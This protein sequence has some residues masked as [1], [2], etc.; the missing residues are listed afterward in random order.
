MA[1]SF[2]P[3]P[4]KGSIMRSVRRA[5]ERRG[6]AGGWRESMTLRLLEKAGALPGIGPACLGWAGFIH[7][8]EGRYTQAVAHYEAARAR[9]RSGCAALRYDTGI[10]LLKSGDAARAEPELRAAVACSG[11][12]PWAMLQLGLCL[13]SLNLPQEAERCFRSCLD[14]Q[15]DCEGGHLGLID[16]LMR[17]QLASE[18]DAVLAAA[19]RLPPH[20]LAGFKLPEHLA[21]F[22]PVSGQQ[23]EAIRELLDRRPPHPLAESAALFLGRIET[24]RSN[25][26]TAAALFRQAGLHR[27]GHETAAGNLPATM[28]AVL[29][30]GQAKAGTSSLFHHLSAHPQFEPSLLKEP[31][32]WSLNHHCGMDW[33]A[34]LFPHLPADS[35]RITGEGSTTYFPNPLAP[36]RVARSL[37][38][39]KLV[40]LLREP[41]ARAH[42]EY[43]MHVRLGLQ[44]EPFETVV[45][46]E[47]A[48]MPTCPLDH[49]TL[50]GDPI[51]GGSLSRSAA[52]PHL[53][54]W[55][56]HFPPEQLLVLRNDELARDLPGV[57]RRLCDFLGIAPFVPD[58]PARHNEGRYPPI[59]PVLERR[60]RDWFE[61]H[62]RALEDFLATLPSACR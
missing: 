42:S 14:R 62:Q 30:I 60:L 48:V 39:V 50:G 41:V 55:L 27:W 53:K 19:T 47:L 52:L 12:A 20:A 6:A 5:I 23:F 45:A 40:L 56:A 28:P 9:G 37:P 35:G 33:Y 51:P 10:A 34:S 38:S 54:R 61:P 7:A 22:Y 26:A 43:W 36:A 8:T 24:Q 31:H 17:Q 57:M 1:M 11:G 58:D 59:C 25:S 32:Y 4:L 3:A 18:V 29:V 16:A 46:K 13:L 49:E 2:S 21:T 15:P 44:T